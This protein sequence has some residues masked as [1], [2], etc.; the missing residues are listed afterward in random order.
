MRLLLRAHQNPV[1]L[2][3]A[4]ARTRV[5]V[6]AAE[7]LLF[8]ATRG[9]GAGV[10]VGVR[11]GGGVGRRLVVL[12]LLMLLRHTSAGTVGEAWSAGTG[13]RG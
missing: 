8:V 13:R 4:V 5:L 6:E 3:C 2:L 11:A 7:S 1:V 10:V 12:L 9:G